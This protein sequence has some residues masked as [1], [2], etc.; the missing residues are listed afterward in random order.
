MATMTS[1]HPV[2]IK[3]KPT[4]RLICDEVV[5]CPHCGKTPLVS[6][7]YVRRICKSWNGAER[8]F[9]IPR[10]FCSSC[11]ILQR[12]LPSRQVPYKHY[13]KDVIATHLKYPPDKPIPGNVS[14]KTVDLLT[15][16]L[17]CDQTIRNWLEWEKAGFPRLPDHPT[18]ACFDRNP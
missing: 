11:K 5:I 4:T 17:P 1:Y 16:S 15:G 6:R 9:E 10:G 13:R 12:L 14:Q 18:Y 3:G 8:W 7:D 2:R